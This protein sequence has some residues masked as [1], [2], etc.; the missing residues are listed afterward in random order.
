[1]ILIG[2]AVVLTV[3]I[4]VLFSWLCSRVDEPPRLLVAKTPKSAPVTPA[5]T[6]LRVTSVNGKAECLHAGTAVWTTVSEGDELFSD[7]R[8]RTEKDAAV[9]LSVNDKS[10]F[11]L[12]GRSE[13]NVRELT[14]TVHQIELALGRINVDYDFYEDRILKITA[15]DELDAVAETQ[16]AKFVVQRVGDAVTVA[17]QMGKVKLTAK[18]ETVTLGPNS[19]SRV[20]KGNAPEKPEPIPLEVLLKIANPKKGPDKDRTTII[21]GHTDVGAL[22]LVEDEVVDVDDTGRFRAAVPRRQGVQQVD[23]VSSTAW[24]S[25]EKRISVYSVPDDG[26]VTD[27]KVKWGTSAGEK[28]TKKGRSK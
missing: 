6:H 10:H 18:A 21:S 5:K 27:A 22:V 8:L 4:G 19:F 2:I 3:G 16:A 14:E 25:A 26:E 28:K 13:L 20:T 12:A 9:Q 1:M 24:G 23:I 15:S 7:D 11:E 17:T